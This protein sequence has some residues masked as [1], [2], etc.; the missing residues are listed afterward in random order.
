M[1]DD[2]PNDH[3]DPAYER[4]CV[5]RLVALSGE[6]NQVISGFAGALPRM[7]RYCGR[8]VDAV[9]RVA[10]GD[11]NSFTGVMCES[12]HDVWMELHQDLVV[13][14]EIDRTAEGSF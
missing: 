13:L 8:L 5:D 11:A 14:L 6:A 7:N 10:R 3:T 2:A 12:F 1:R 9:V 4:A